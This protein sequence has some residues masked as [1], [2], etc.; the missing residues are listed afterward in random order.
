MARFFFIAC[1]FV[2]EKIKERALNR[3]LF[4]IFFD[5]Y[6]FYTP[7]SFNFVEKRRSGVRLFHSLF[8]STQ[9]IEVEETTEL[10][11]VNR[12]PFQRFH[13]EFNRNIGLYGRKKFAE[14]NFFSVLFNLV[15]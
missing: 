1:V 12:L 13:I 3:A 7:G 9:F 15:L 2:G 5:G 10:L 8:E 14:E 11:F 4:L 6:F